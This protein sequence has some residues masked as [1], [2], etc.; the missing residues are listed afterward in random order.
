VPEL[1]VYLASDV[2]LQDSAVQRV[3]VVLERFLHLHDT[4]RHPVT[5]ADVQVGQIARVPPRPPSCAAAQRKPPISPMLRPIRAAAATEGWSYRPASGFDLVVLG[6]S[7][8]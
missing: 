6:Q 5:E 8:A 1:E 2:G 4:V 3:C 7:A